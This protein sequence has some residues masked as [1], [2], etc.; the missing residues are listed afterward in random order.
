MYVQGLDRPSL[1]LIKRLDLAMKL[2]EGEESAVDDFAVALLQAVDYE[3]EDTVIRT[4]KNI[5]F[6]MCDEATSQVLLLVQEDRSHIN[7]SDSEGEL[8]AEAIGA[9]QQDNARRQGDLILPPLE[10]QVIPGIAMVRTF[11]RFYKIKVTKELDMAIR[12]GQYPNADSSP[13]SYSSHTGAPQ[14]WDETT[15]QS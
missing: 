12:F 2:N 11:P 3:G 7:P 9:F 1:S 5:C 14:R 4:H 15:G 8:I 13:S 6:Q 10:M